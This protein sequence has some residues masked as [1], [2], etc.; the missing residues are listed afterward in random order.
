[1]AILYFIRKRILVI[2]L[3][4]TAVVSGWISLSRRSNDGW[5]SII[6]MDGRGY[7][8]YLP[9]LFIYND[10][11][12]SFYQKESELAGDTTNFINRIDGKPVNKYYCGEAVLQLPFFGAAH[13][14]AK[15]AGYKSNG[16]TQPYQYAVAFAGL[17]YFLAGLFFLWKLLEKFNFRKRVIF[18]VCICFAFGTNLFHYGI[19]ESSMSHI[20]SFAAIT[21]FLFFTRCFMLK[22]S[23]KLLFLL[24]V[25]FGLIAIIRPVNMMIILALPVMAGNREN[26]KAVFRWLFL[27]KL[28]LFSAILIFLSICFIQAGL[29]YWQ[30]GQWFVW[31]Y[32]NEGFNFLHPHIYG[33]LLSYDRGMFLY[34]PITLLSLTGLIVIF[35]RSRFLFAFLLLL[36]CVIIY[37]ISSWYDW[38]YGYGFGLR[39]YVEYYA[40]FAFSFAFLVDFSFSNK[41]RTMSFGLLT[42]LIAFSLVIFYCIQEYQVTH[43]ILHSGFMNKERYW[44]V[45]LHTDKKYEGLLDQEPFVFESEGNFNDM[46]GSVEW[47]GLE[48]IKRGPAYSGNYSSKIDSSLVYSVG[49]CRNMNDRIFDDSVRMKISAWVMRENAETSGQLV[50]IQTNADSTFFYNGIALPPFTVKGKWEKI[51]NEITVPKRVVK[52]EY[53]RAFFIRFSGTIYIDDF[54]IELADK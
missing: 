30:T 1:M 51:Q 49:F 35:R 32:K 11:S 29:Y 26:L 40:L 36:F 13:L 17:F 18:I 28:Y 27:N 41:R 25:L 22:P 37:V 33:T 6:F 50:I 20:Y 2:F 19:I 39:A 14:Y 23:V 53:L 12:C 16:Y 38:R 46:E 21:A 9:A 10:P 3:L 43:L 54:S 7:Y 45:F 47:P 48:T 34:I 52:R 24:A 8:T 31:S 4:T 44:K 5:K 15:L 42:G